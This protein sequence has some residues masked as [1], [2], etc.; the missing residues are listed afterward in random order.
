LLLSN[1]TSPLGFT[2]VSVARSAGVETVFV[3]HGVWIPEDIS[4][5]VSHA[6]H[7]VVM[8]S[9]EAELCHSW[10]GNDARR[11]HVLGQPRFD[12]HSLT[13]ADDARRLLGTMLPNGLRRPGKVA[14]VATQP[15][16]GDRTDRQVAAAIA[17]VRQLARSE[18]WS[19]VLAIHPAQ[20]HA[21]Y[22]S[23]AE[24]GDSQFAVVVAPRETPLTSYLAA[25]TVLLIDRSTSGL[26][27]ALLGVPV[28]EMTEL[29]GP[30][31]G[32]AAAGVAL[33][34]AFEHELA[35][36]IAE[37]A[38][39]RSAF[40]GAYPRARSALLRDYRA[41]GRSSARTAALVRGLV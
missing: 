7:V 32:L 1:D 34:A 35:K 24:V 9:R 16:S 23:L 28:V 13:S 17:A 29:G 31:L 10:P 39:P 12:A 2:A 36:R 20:P 25:A 15:S 14:V 8:S 5:R 6:D 38:D 19:V 30:R 22:V 18:P 41:D 4:W 37:A 11:V 27:A 3:Q 33:E 26:D 21:R 40:R